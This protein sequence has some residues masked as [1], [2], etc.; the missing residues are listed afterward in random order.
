VSQERGFVIYDRDTGKNL[1][2]LPLTYPIGLSVD[3]FRKAGYDAGW[4][5]TTIEEVERV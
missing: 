5:W 4:T 2:T 1:V 3:L